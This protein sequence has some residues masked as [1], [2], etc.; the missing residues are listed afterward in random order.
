MDRALVVDD[1]RS[2]Q[3]ILSEILSE[4]GMQVDL[5][6]NLTAAVALISQQSHR[7]AVIDLSLG[8]DDHHNQDG[9]YILRELGRH[10]PACVSILLTGF[11]TVE[12]AVSVLTDLGA[13]TCLR[14]EIFH[15]GQFRELVH[16]AL[17][18]PPTFLTG[19]SGSAGMD[20]EQVSASRFTLAPT[21][22][23]VEDDAGWR[24]IFQELLTDAGYQ[25]RLCSSYGEA[26]GCLRREDYV[27]AV[28]DLSLE[29]SVLPELTDGKDTDPPLDGMRL[30]ANLHA[31]SIPTVVV[32]GVASPEDIERVYAEQDIFAFLEKQSFERRIFLQTIREAAQSRTYPAG[33]DRLTVREMEVLRMLSQGLTN[34][35]IAEHLVI[36]PNTVKRHLKAVFEKLGVHTRSAAAALAV[37]WFGIKPT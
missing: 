12:I 35:E 4:E 22:L 9:L 36:T 3:Q 19:Q 27:L 16:R 25:V 17:A 29:G 24:S 13:Y 31:D 34:K 11:A 14:K 28:A 18:N 2:W 5:A 20:D 33:L 1:D 26:L 23:V 15:R 30:L 8:G 21:A 6:N 7:L 37:N 10:D 32:S